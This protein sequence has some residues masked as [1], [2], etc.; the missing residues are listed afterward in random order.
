MSA[1]KR[2]L[3]LGAAGRDYHNFNMVFRDNPGYEV[4]GFTHTQLPTDAR[5][6]PAKL[7]GRLYK[8]G[9][10]I[11]REKDVGGLMKR[12]RADLVCFSYSDVTHA[13]VMHLAS[14]ALAG[15]A[16]FLLL[17]PNETMLKSKKK[18]VAVCATRTGAGKSPVTEYISLLLRKMGFRPA[19]IRHPMPYGDLV[20]QEVQVFREIR[21]LDK[22]SCTVEERED[23]ERH[24]KNGFTVY[25]GVDYAKV[26][27]MAEK[28][29]DI[30]IWDG[31]NNDYP[32]IRPDQM[33]TVADAMRPGH[34]LEYHPGE[35]NFRMADVIAINKWENNR[36]GERIIRD[37]ARNISPRAKI[38]KISMDAR[39]EGADLHGK[40]A[41]VVED[42]PTI[43]HGG[44]PHGIGYITA[45]KM[46][47]KIINPKKYAHGMY[48]RIYDEYPH[49]GSVVPAIGYSKRQLADLKKTIEAA[50][51]EGI[52]WA[53]PANPGSLIR[54]GVPIARVE[55]KLKGNTH[56]EMAVRRL[57]GKK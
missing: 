47:C 23:Y 46:G 2:V 10:R 5:L 28:N 38:V 20:K 41:V 43:T 4:V 17:G 1:R 39:V 45:K 27:D 55:Y 50:N 6:Y 40:S 52:V 31:G 32:F 16:S 56:I 42:G 26:L 51:P 34:E 14:Q 49:I 9:V 35:A 57:M 7:A 11:Y 21:D 22:Y 12:L 48:K 44:M 29:S 15:G 8:K 19:I 53:T 36:E 37:N 18:V 54:L 33:I 13:H 3:I 25:A 24:I 30:I